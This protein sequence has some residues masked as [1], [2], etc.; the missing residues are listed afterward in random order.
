MN[1][2]PNPS[3]PLNRLTFD[4]LVDGALS[5]DEYRRVLLALEQQ[6]T[7]WRL[8]AEAFLEAQAWRGDFS[9]LRQGSTALPVAEKAAPAEANKSRFAA[10]WLRMSLVAA[11]SF[12]LA[13]VG[14]RAFWQQQNQLPPKH[15]TNVIAN[16][17][18][19]VKPGTANNV[20]TSLV[21][22]TQPMGLVHLAVNRGAGEEQEVMEMP[23]YSEAAAAEVLSNVSPALPDDLVSALEA[24]GHQVDLQRQLVPIPLA[25]G[26]QMMLPIEG[27]RIVPKSRPSY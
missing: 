16:V 19:P 5:A 1:S 17:P 26:R 10:D 20:P 25:D 8:C 27:Y 4:R 18:G 15:G 23:V 2:S 24:D 14:A 22:N 21:S 9:T 7:A 3:L 12:L 6:P 11:A 13:F